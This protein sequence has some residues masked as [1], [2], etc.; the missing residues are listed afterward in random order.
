VTLPH[1]FSDGQQAL[2]GEVNANFDAIVDAL[3][4]T[5]VDL[6]GA[7]TAT[8]LDFEAQGFQFD[9]RDWELNIAFDTNSQTQGFVEIYSTGNA[10]LSGINWDYERKL[11]LRFDAYANTQH[12]N[13]PE[14][15]D[16]WVPV[17]GWVVF[18]TARGGV[19]YTTHGLSDSQMQNPDNSLS[20]VFC[21]RVV[22]GE[23]QNALSFPGIWRGN[24]RFSCLNGTNGPAIV[25]L[26]VVPT[27]AAAE[28]LSLSRKISHYHYQDPQGSVFTVAEQCSSPAPAVWYVDSDG[29]MFGS[30]IPSVDDPVNPLSAIERP[31]G[32]VGNDSDC[33]DNNGAVNPDAPDVVDS[34]DNDCDGSIDESG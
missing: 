6:L 27:E 14:G 25:D 4:T 23:Q 16:W 18:S 8:A 30:A 29:D 19:L 17:E 5:N 11:L 28:T 7:R 34:I 26:S 12:T 1:R 2:A 15:T 20:G 32:Y 21:S 24:G 13:C 22:E 31:V 33:D 3:N 10:F 9:L